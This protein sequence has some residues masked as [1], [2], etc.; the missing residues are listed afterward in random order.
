MHITLGMVATHYLSRISRCLRSSLKREI[1]RHIETVSNCLSHYNIAHN[2]LAE[3]NYVQF[4][5]R[6]LATATCRMHVKPK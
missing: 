4:E 6:K 3:C 1:I 2:R 5:F